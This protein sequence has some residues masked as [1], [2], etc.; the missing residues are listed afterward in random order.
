[1]MTFKRNTANP[2]TFLFLVL[3]YGVSNGFVYVTLPFLLT[4]HGFSVAAAAS[5]TALGLSA[6]IWRFLWS[7]MTDLSLSLHKWYLIGT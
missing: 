6:N 3:P 7:P 1:M 2:F 4:K 5:I